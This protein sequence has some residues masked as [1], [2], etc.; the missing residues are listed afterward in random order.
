MLIEIA[1][2][3]IM[4]TF[5]FCCIKIRL[6]TPIH[7][8]ETQMLKYCIGGK[9]VMNI[10]TLYQKT[11]EILNEFGRKESSLIAVL[12]AIQEEY[13]YLPREIFP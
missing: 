12:Q 8:F 11:D 1:K 2:K 13:A 6:D 9:T 3:K 4:F 7:F 5:S 10:E